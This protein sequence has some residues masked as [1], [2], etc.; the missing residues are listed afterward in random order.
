MS[1]EQSLPINSVRQEDGNLI[2]SEAQI[3]TIFLKNP[4]PVSGFIECF[5]CQL[6]LTAICEALKLLA[7]QKGE[8]CILQTFD[9]IV[10]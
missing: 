9:M 4:F 8:V 1:H 3:S 7:W 6:Y 10:F 5:I 2:D